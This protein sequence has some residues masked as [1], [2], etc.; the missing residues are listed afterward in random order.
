[1]IV[2]KNC[3]TVGR[4]QPSKLVD[5]CAG[6]A[7][8]LS[9]ISACI[10]LYPFG[11]WFPLQKQ[12]T[13][14]STK[15]AQGVTL[16]ARIELDAVASA[17][18]SRAMISI[19][20]LCVQQSTVNDTLGLGSPTAASAGSQRRLT[21]RGHHGLVRAFCSIRMPDSGHIAPVQLLYVAAT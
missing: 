21:K 8:T 19:S 13:T 6:V 7:T 2:R 9:C 18:C 15:A 20:F 17:S 5:P 12:N 1:M 11:A 3:R 14:A 4:L 10:G 16:I